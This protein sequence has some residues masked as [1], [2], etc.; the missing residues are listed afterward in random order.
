MF[1]VHRLKY[2]EL[3][4]EQ[5]NSLYPAQV[6]AMEAR[7]TKLGKAKFFYYLSPNNANW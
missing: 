3:G 1:Y 7:A 5:Y 6:K 2:I 4:N